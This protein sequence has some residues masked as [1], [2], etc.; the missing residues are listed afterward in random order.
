MWLFR[1]VRYRVIGAI[2][3]HPVVEQP[4]TIKPIKCKILAFEIQAP[5]GCDIFYIIQAYKPDMPRRSIP[6]LCKIA[7]SLSK[8]PTPCLEVNDFEY[9]YAN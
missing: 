7:S 4:D 6:Y 2:C 8:P 5:R 1:P 9:K 3:D